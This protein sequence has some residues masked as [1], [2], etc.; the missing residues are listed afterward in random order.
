[1]TWFKVDDKMP[2]HAKI[3]AAGNDD[4]SP[5][6]FPASDPRAVAVSA[7]GR[8][9]TFPDGTVELGDVVKPFGTDK[10]NYI[11][12]FSNVGPEILLTG[13]GVGIIST[14]PGDKYAVMDGTSMACP[15]V[16][17]ASAKL[18]AKQPAIL[19]MPRDQARSDA[20]LQAILQ[21]ARS[22]GFPGTLEGKG[23]IK[24]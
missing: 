24:V 2:F 17:G 9:G 6:S 11:A 13:P 12:A 4:R 3:V 16:V 15:A 8:I 23:L 14:F 21:A 5:V 18:L 22:L 20:M 10:K 7:L 19:G 1:M